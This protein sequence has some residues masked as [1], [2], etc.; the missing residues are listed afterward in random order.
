ML[1]ERANR[2]LDVRRYVSVEKMNKLLAPVIFAWLFASPVAATVGEQSLTPEVALKAIALFKQD[3]LGE[4]ANGALAVVL[5]FAQSS[6]QVLVVIDEKIFPFEIGSIDSAA[7]STFLGAFLAGNVEHQLITGTKENR[8]YEGILLMLKTYE[9]MRYRG[10]IDR[11]EG[12]EHW[13]NL[14]NKGDLE[15]AIDM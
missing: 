13:I 1:D 10:V 14:R 5:K 12:F 7:E 2:T 11:V 3:P 9:I 6:S 15:S 4:Q 8:P